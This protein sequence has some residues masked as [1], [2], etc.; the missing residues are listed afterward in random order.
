MQFPPGLNDVFR[1][2][3]RITQN[4]PLQAGSETKSQDYSYMIEDEAD[5]NGVAVGTVHFHA[6]QS[7]IYFLRSTSSTREYGQRIRRLRT[8]S[9]RWTIRS[10]LRVSV[11]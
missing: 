4:S 11:T 6:F 10:L 7:F 2:L 3:A 1:N 9:F 5:G 8:V